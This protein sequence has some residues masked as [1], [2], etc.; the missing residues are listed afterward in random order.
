MTRSRRTVTLARALRVLADDLQ[1][2]PLPALTLK[3][4]HARDPGA[5]EPDLA[6][7]GSAT[8]CRA[9]KPALVATALLVW[10]GGALWLASGATDPSLPLAQVESGF[11]P[12]VPLDRFAEPGADAEP[13]WVVDAEWP[14]ER[15]AALGLPFDPARAGR[16][17]RAEV[18]LHRS[19]E[20]LAVRVMR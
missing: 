17:V 15:L 10:I 3:P 12:V 6:T 5:P 7:A 8:T 16:A 2:Q 19:G 9:W 13:A 20:V 11:V 18:L 4:R 1:A 14:A